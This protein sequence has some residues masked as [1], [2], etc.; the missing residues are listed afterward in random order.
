M[1]QEGDYPRPGQDTAR[2]STH[3]NTQT[4]LQTTLRLERSLYSQTRFPSGILATEQRCSQ[5][6]AQVFLRSCRNCMYRR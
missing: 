2:A 3:L 1:A 6:T 4:G 5:T